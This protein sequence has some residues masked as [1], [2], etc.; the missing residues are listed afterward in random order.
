MAGAGGADDVVTGRLRQKAARRGSQKW[1]QIAV[2]AAPQRLQPPGLAP[3][4]WRSPLADD[5]HAEYRD[6]AFLER[7][8]LGHLAP[9]LAA[10]WP[11]GG[12]VWDGLAT[13]ADGVV[14]VEAK[15]HLRE[16]L[17]TPCA[18]RDPDSR[19]RIAAALGQAREA[20]GARGGGD[21]MEVFYQSANRL[22]LLWWLNAQGVRAHLLMVG[23]LGDAGMRGPAT[24]EAW[25]AMARAIRQALGL[26]EAHPLRDRVHWVHPP[27]EG[28]VQIAG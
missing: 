11:R 27:V 3:L 25:Q 24:P 9:A 18:A 20:L 16:A 17:S 15:A 4:T 7:L 21:W 28:L 19:A 8:G 6:A 10:F 5:D 22:A 2:A 12:P 14:L 13:C 1:L 26:P 23:F